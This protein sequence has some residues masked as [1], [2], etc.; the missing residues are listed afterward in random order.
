MRGAL[1]DIVGDESDGN[2]AESA[3]A[4]N[5]AK[6][7]C[8]GPQRSD[9]MTQEFEAGRITHASIQNET[10]DHNYEILCDRLNR[11]CEITKA[12]SKLVVRLHS[13]RSDPKTIHINLELGG[14]VNM[15]LLEHYTRVMRTNNPGITDKRIHT[16]HGSLS[17]VILQLARLTGIPFT[18]EVANTWNEQD[19]NTIANE[20]SSIC[21]ACNEYQADGQISEDT[22]KQVKRDLMIGYQVVIQR[23]SVVC[24][25]LVLVKTGNFQIHDKA[26]AIA[27][28]E[29]GRAIDL[30][31]ATLLSA[32]WAC[33]LIMLVGD[34]PKL[35]NP[36]Q[37]QLC[38]STFSRLNY[39]GFPIPVLTH[40][41]R[42][43]SDP[44]LLLCR[45][46]NNEPRIPAV[47]GSFKTELE[48]EAKRVNR[49]IWGKSSVIVVAIPRMLLPSGT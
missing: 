12:P 31:I 11:I 18:N 16:V 37:S 8:A 45:R 40:T 13:I 15:A 3:H 39:T 19:R 1:E 47:P 20:L 10:V 38:H 41:S 28:E 48:N 42:F 30:D 6:E 35:D 5:L 36:F 26:H 22:R 25:T 44:F 34:D 23:A 43:T 27:L 14:T 9:G 46:L 17:Y 24:S 2:D 7:V 32:H 33:D 29:P 4:G 49:N 21:Y